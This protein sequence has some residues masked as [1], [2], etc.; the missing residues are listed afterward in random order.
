MATAIPTPGTGSYAFQT[1]GTAPTP[2]GGLIANGYV[3]AM[4]P[5]ATE[6]NY[7]FQTLMNAG[8]WLQ[9]AQCRFREVEAYRA[10]S[11]TVSPASTPLIKATLDGAG[12]AALDILSIQPAALATFRSLIALGGAVSAAPGLEIDWGGG[13]DPYGWIFR[14]N[15]S[16]NTFFDFQNTHSTGGAVVQAGL[17][18]TTGETTYKAGMVGLSKY[19]DTTT[20]VNNTITETAIFADTLP[21]GRLRQGTTIRI[22][23]AGDISWV[24]GGSNDLTFRL[25][26]GSG[27]STIITLV[28]GAGAWVA[29][30]SGAI[31][32]EALFTVTTASATGEIKAYGNAQVQ[33]SGNTV[34][35]CDYGN[36]SSFD[37][38]V[39]CPIAITAQW[40]LASASN[41]LDTRLVHIEIMDTPA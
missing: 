10:V 1:S 21:A 34:I 22:K 26:L 6:F 17:I 4:I 35:S 32:F 19:S 9:D 7:L 15:V 33:V 24:N 2:S 20:S 16:T 28:L 31:V 5:A 29:P 13:S 8:D 37:T 30:V 25:K 39:A 38:T 11:Y 36:L 23:W 40:Q 27:V 14:V 18:Q 3:P 41:D 12:D